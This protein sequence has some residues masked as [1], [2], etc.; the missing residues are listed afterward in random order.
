MDDTVYFL[1]GILVFS[2]ILG[3]GVVEVWNP[4]ILWNIFEK[5]KTNQ[6]D[7][8]SYGYDTAHRVG[9]AITIVISVYMIVSMLCTWCLDWDFPLGAGIFGL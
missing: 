7:T 3:I 5:W 8:S 4:E 6:A 9:G 1:A 2:A